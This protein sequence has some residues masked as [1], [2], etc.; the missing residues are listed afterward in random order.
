MLNDCLFLALNF[1]DLD[2][3]AI[4][5]ETHRLTLTEMLLQATGWKSGVHGG[6]E[7]SPIESVLGYPMPVRHVRVFEEQDQQALSLVPSPTPTPVTE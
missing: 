3:R 6:V 5:Q 1:D 7:S 2:D 4:R